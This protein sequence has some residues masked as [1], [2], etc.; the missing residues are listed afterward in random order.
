MYSSNY[1]IN[2]NFQSSINL[3]LDLNNEKKIEEY[4]PTTDI[5]DVLKIYVKSILGINNDRATTLVGPYGK[6]KSFLLLV[7]SYILGNNKNTKCWNNLVN[8]IKKID[9]ELYEMIT[10]LKN[11]KI[12]LMPIIINSNYDNIIQSFQLALNESLKREKLEGLIPE[13]TYNVC[14]NLID[15]W[16]KD[17][18]IKKKILTKCLELNKIDINDLISELKNYSPL[19]YKQ[20]ER[21]YNCMNIGLEF[22]PLVNNDIVKI[23]SDINVELT[24]KGYSGM[25]IVFDEF[26]K[27][28]ESNS[29]NLMNDL[30]I[31]QDMAELCSRSATKQQINLC[32]VTHKSISLYFYGEK[33]NSGMNSFKTVEGRFKEIKFNRSL[34]ENYQIISYAIKKNDPLNLIAKEYIL[35]NRK[36]YDELRSISVFSDEKVEEELF[37]GCFPLN[38]LTVY[39]LIQLSEFVAQNERTL[40]TFLSDSDEN[41]FKS[42]I[43]NNNDG[44]FNVDKIYDYFY[45]LLQIEE[46]NHIRNI[47]Y[48]AE[49]ILSKTEDIIEKKIIKVLALILMVNDFDR[50]QPSEEVISIALT[51]DI[52]HIK[53]TINRLLEKH[54]LRRNILNNL[55][56][57][58]LSNSK[59]IDDKIEYLAKTKFKNLK[60]SEYVTLIN[61][62]NYV[63][64]RRYNERYKI[65]RFFRIIFIEEKEFIELC[66]FEYILKDKYCD[67]LIV[68]LIRKNML[69]NEILNK[70]REINDPRII[71][72]YPSE[73]V[74]DNFDRL[75]IRYACLLE[76]KNKNEID[77]ISIHEID[78]LIEEIE[79]D[80]KELIRKYF[81]INVK[82]YS[83]I[84]INV[85]FNELLSLT[86]EDIYTVPIIFNNELINKR[87]VTM[88]YQKAI[89][90]VIDYLLDKKDEFIYSA[91]SPEMSIKR[92]VIDYNKND[93]N[94]RSVI[95]EIKSQISN[96]NNN[97]FN[98]NEFM[99]MLT[100]PPYGIR[101][102]ILP[103]ILSQAV[104]E[105]SDNVILYYQNKEI[106]LCS[107]NIVKSVLN[108]KYNIGFSKSSKEQKIYL[109]NMMKLFN[110]TS[111]KNF[112]KDTILLSTAIKK[113]FVGQPQIIRS[114]SIKNNYL[115]IEDSVIVYKSAFLSFNINPY[116]SIFDLPSKAFKTKDYQELYEN[117]SV[118]KKLFE[119]KL[120][121]YKNSIIKKIKELF[122]ISYQSSLKMEL[123]KRINKFIKDGYKM[124]LSDNEK[125]ILNIIQNDLSFD[126]LES[127]NNICK[128]CVHL[129]IEDWDDDY[130]NKTY[131]ILV[132][133]YNNIQNS[134]QIKE[135]QL[136]AYV[137]VCEETPMGS[138]LKN[139]LESILDEFSESVSTNEKISILN[140]FIKKML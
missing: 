32:C 129:Y 66:N 105:L 118:L 42:F 69:E 110:V 126:D 6:G 70:I 54:Y 83:S 33:K 62:R 132:R 53:N 136:N 140:D 8:K 50:L 40:F 59:Q 134:E 24:K 121:N 89:N 13:T 61:D 17:E 41:S 15:K 11:K 18:Q 20:F 103:L 12:S 38:P 112:R 137:N 68:Y 31:I 78:L 67:G 101:I 65:T 55:L 102:G 97:K 3:E 123:N 58:A 25:F 113:F 34:E 22:N 86:L 93:N 5:C 109:D 16:M 75:L 85:G 91:T 122:E 46:T 4:I 64:P 26:S 92:A 19:A 23:Y 45:N 57:F 82:Y 111:T 56:S 30:K 135:S 138:L 48:R 63:I 116:E 74:N 71:V 43:Y 37:E 107:G 60:L 44:L 72:K 49:S 90:H 98:I 29:I 127:V 106:D 128:A 133:F 76:I 14:L 73:F 125:L 130:S 1:Y 96:S 115:N 2:K 99:T 88:Q 9:T 79:V 100:L 27:F 28:I 84:N 114:N 10:E 52:K 117:I 131:E 36:F 124:I 47:W 21:L 119:V 139:N 87:N 108:D 81:E 35:K 51:I 104:S 120:C 39:I 80:I 77:E 7:L 95:E 94:F